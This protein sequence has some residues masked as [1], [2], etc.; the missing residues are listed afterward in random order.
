M[1]TSNNTMSGTKTCRSEDPH[2]KCVCVYL[3]CVCSRTSSVSIESN[4]GERKEKKRKK[5]PR[6][7]SNKNANKLRQKGQSKGETRYRV[8]NFE[9]KTSLKWNKSHANWLTTMELHELD[10]ITNYFV[11][12][13][14]G[15][16]PF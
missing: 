12:I 7:K 3:I 15:I 8:Y 13:S 11:A 1:N 6:T 9:I 10:L 5:A 2:M 16:R 4:R 14:K